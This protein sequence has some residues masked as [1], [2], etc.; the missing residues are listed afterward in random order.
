MIFDDFIQKEET[1]KKLSVISGRLEDFIQTFRMLKPDE[2]KMNL[3]RWLENF[4]TIENIDYDILLLLLDGLQIYRD[5]EVDNAFREVMT[6]FSWRHFGKED[7]TN[8]FLC[9]LGNNTESSFRIASNHNDPSPPFFEADI[10]TLL[11]RIEPNPDAVIVF[12]DDI[13]QSGGQVL[14][15][16]KKYLGL[17]VKPGEITDEYESRI[18]I[19]TQALKKVFRSK[20]IVLFF[21]LA[22][23]NGYNKIKEE[24]KDS[25]G[26]EVEIVIG[27]DVPYNG[28]FGSDTDIIYV[29]KN[30]NHTYA[31]G[32]LKD[33]P[34]KAA[35][36][37][38]EILREVGTQLLRI[39]RRNKDLIPGKQ[40]SKDKYMSRALGYGNEAKLLLGQQN[41]PTSTIT[42]LWLP[43]PENFDNAVVIEG[44][45]ISWRPLFYRK[46]KILGNDKSYEKNKTFPM[47]RVNRWQN[48]IGMANPYYYDL[49]TIGVFNRARAIILHGHSPDFKTGLTDILNKAEDEFYLRAKAKSFA[50]LREW[51][52]FTL[53]VHNILLK[54]QE[55]SGQLLALKRDMIGL[56]LSATP[57]V[58]QNAKEELSR[59]VANIIEKHSSKI[60]S[61]IID[62]PTRNAAL[63]IQTANAIN[64]VT[65]AEIYISDKIAIA[66]TA[67]APRRSFFREPENSGNI[68]CYI[69]NILVKINDDDFGQVKAKLKPFG[70]ILNSIRVPQA[71]KEYD[72]SP[73]YFISDFEALLEINEGQD[74]PGLKNLFA[75][76]LVICSIYTPQYIEYFIFYAAS[77][78]NE[79][80]LY[81]G[82]QFAVDSGNENFIDYWV[83]GT[84]CKS[85]AYINIRK[86][87]TAPLKSLIF[88]LL[89]YYNRHKNE[90]GLNKHL[91]MIIDT[92]M[93]GKY[94]A[95]Y[96]IPE[97]ILGNNTQ[98]F[99]LDIL[100]KGPLALMQLAESGIDIF[101]ELENSLITDFLT[102]EIADNI[103]L[104]TKLTTNKINLVVQKHQ[105]LLLT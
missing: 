40:W 80:I 83:E 16:F 91:L 11:R 54:E 92:Y 81:S 27:S 39:D 9:P 77:S 21:H 10:N 67:P 89:R 14:S 47:I 94:F 88:P 3:I 86:H 56:V 37:I 6:K 22:F 58:L 31:S 28:A 82:L 15:I 36:R 90:A 51:F 34:Y 100:N 25:L 41:V 93:D 75:E 61:V 99:Y 55:I 18:E 98:N 23:F 5:K 96:W 70:V 85:T 35:R 29:L 49:V 73:K 44:K 45:E 32:V 87:I 50:N 71:P 48:N 2:I 102:P 12:M 60:L 19:E 53:D 69:E 38:Y 66:D 20:K 26:L 1:Q 72:F 104:S 24:L 64:S 13:L 52:H 46:P 65:P 68:S 30:S 8:L 76:L 57:A 105:Y 74:Q 63:L 78:R 7:F 42:A 79:F 33:I 97:K 62:C 4:R 59:L 84:R 95:D 17:P 101:E 43:S 103:I